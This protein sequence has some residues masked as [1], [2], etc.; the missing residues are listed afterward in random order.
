MFFLAEKRDMWKHIINIHKVRNA[1]NIGEYLL[2]V[3]PALS[4]CHDV[5][6]KWILQRSWKHVF[7]YHKHHHNLLQNGNAC[8]TKGSKITLYKIVVATFVKN[9]HFYV[10][11]QF[12]DLS[13]SN[14]HFIVDNLALY[15]DTQVT[16]FYREYYYDVFSM[17]FASGFA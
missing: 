17:L 3:E 15:S 9:Q 14:I 16:Q 4:I 8:F 11:Y 1:R 6:H 13:F 12:G 7:Q 10:A 5:W 2:P